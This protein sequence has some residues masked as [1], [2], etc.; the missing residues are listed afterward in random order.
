ME[1][2]RDEPP[3]GKSQHYGESRQRSQG[4]GNED[5]QLIS[6]ISAPGNYQ[7]ETAGKGSH[8]GD[9]SQREGND[10]SAS[11]G[12]YVIIKGLPNVTH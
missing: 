9:C 10:P 12:Q 8:G 4:H 11:H 6:G 7:P 2:E 3:N 5:E 1:K